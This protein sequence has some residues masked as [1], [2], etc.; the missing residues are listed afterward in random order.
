MTGIFKRAHIQDMKAPLKTVRA[1]VAGFTP[2]VRTS[3]ARVRSAIRKALPGAEE[4]ISYGIPAYKV[5][6]R[7][8]IYFAGW[9][10][11][12]S[13]YPANARLVAAFANELSSYEVNNKGTIRFPLSDPV[14]VRLIARV[15]KFRAREAAEQRVLELWPELT[16]GEASAEAVAAIAYASSHHTAW[17]WDGVGG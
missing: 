11:H 15:A 7:T 3:L 14:P 17:L 16:P 13:I 6:G 1:Y 9:K 2:P 5:K 10:R 12:Y 8:V 4:A